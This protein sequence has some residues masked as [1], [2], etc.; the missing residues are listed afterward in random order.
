[1]GEATRPSLAKQESSVRHLQQLSTIVAGFALSD[2]VGQLFRG[3]TG[4]QHGSVG[5]LLLAAFVVTLISFYHGA[6]RHLDDVYLISA[7]AHE[8]RRAGLAVD[9]AFLFAES[10]V[11]FTMAH[12]LGDPPRFFLFLVLLLVVDVAWVIGG[13]VAAPPSHR[14]TME[15]QLLFRLPRGQF[16]AP[17]TWARNNLLFIALALGAWLLHRRWSGLD[18]APIAVLLTLFALA[19]TVND[20]RLSWDFYFPSLRSDGEEDP[21][22]ATGPPQ[23]PPR[24]KRVGGP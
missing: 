4:S 16:F 11:L 9:F 1:M 18:E 21:W 3:D 22:F 12:R 8:V 17:L 6:M 7:S 20:Y 15:S 5:L 10:C 14:L 24:T 13:Y 19:R 2:A 23:T